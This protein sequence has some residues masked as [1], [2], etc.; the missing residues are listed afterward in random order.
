MIYLASS[1][2]NPFYDA[3][4]DCFDQWALPYYDFKANN[5]FNWS[6]IDPEWKAWNRHIYIKKLDDELAVNG[7]ER[8]LRSL[9]TC[10]GLLLITPCGRSAHLELGYVAGWGKPTAIYLKENQEPEL[11]Y[12]L[13]DTVITDIEEV[14]EWASAVCRSAAR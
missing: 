12:R 4:T 14:M 7:F 8:D 9:N 6:Q 5:G 1:W 10:A 3:V 11:M 2:R 13:A